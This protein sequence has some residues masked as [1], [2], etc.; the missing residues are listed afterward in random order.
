MLGNLSNVLSARCICLRWMIRKVVAGAGLTALLAVSVQA[1][2]AEQEDAVEAGR[3]Q[4]SDKCVVCH[5]EEGKGDGV[6]A[7]S[8]NQQPA[9]LSRLSASN[10]G[11]FPM[12][13]AFEKIWGKDSEV[14]STHQMS[15]MPAFYDAPVFGHDADFESS[16]G[17][18][19]PAQIKDI[20]AYLE[21]IQEQ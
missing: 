15:E 11:V 12:S 6:L 4:F 1:E 13:E 14:I 20:I 10:D 17:R 21:T 7:P 16:A 8:L 2:L 18:L 9:D 19:S 3:V 5:G